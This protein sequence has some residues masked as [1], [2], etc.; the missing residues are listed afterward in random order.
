M[1]YLKE[2]GEVKRGQRRG[3]SFLRRDRLEKTTTIFFR[4]RTKE[5]GKVRG[6]S[7]E[8]SQNKERDLKAKQESLGEGGKEGPR[9]E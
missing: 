5:N 6:L 3:T 8:I 4:E 2:K 9:G 7:G 1:A